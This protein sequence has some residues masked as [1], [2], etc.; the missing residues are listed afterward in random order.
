MSNRAF[1][2]LPCAFL[3]ACRSYSAHNKWKA[4]LYESKN[5]FL[6]VHNLRIFCGFAASLLRTRT[7]IQVPVRH[8]KDLFGRDCQFEDLSSKFL[9][10][11]LSSISSLFQFVSSFCSETIYSW[12]GVVAS[13]SV[14]SAWSEFIGNEGR[15]KSGA[16]GV[17]VQTFSVES[18][19]C[20]RRCFHEFLTTVFFAPN[21][22]ILVM[23]IFFSVIKISW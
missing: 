12:N 10:R 18:S 20:T 14:Q 22:P 21:W 23:W 4:C 15:A 7:A 17:G 11:R 13:L 5:F 16:H 2:R 8:S 6:T 1:H 9:H 19:I 3:A